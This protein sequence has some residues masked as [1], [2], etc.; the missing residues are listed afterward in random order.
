MNLVRKNQGNLVIALIL[1]GSWHPQ[2]L[3]IAA[4]MHIQISHRL[5]TYGKQFYGVQPVIFRH[6]EILYEQKSSKQHDTIH[7]VIVLVML[8][9]W[10]DKMVLLLS[11]P[12]LHPLCMYN[13]KCYIW[14]SIHTFEI[15]WLNLHHCRPLRGMA[16]GN[17]CFSPTITTFQMTDWHEKI[18][19]SIELVMFGS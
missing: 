17:D 1:K 3:P 8:K 16:A 13:S 11:L 2:R 15:M 6:D 12:I 10:Y 18:T 19:W 7:S 9:V 5:V 4:Y 14:I